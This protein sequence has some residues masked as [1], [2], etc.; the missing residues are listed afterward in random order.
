[1]TDNEMRKMSRRELLE[2]LVEQ[3]EENEKLKKEL[4]ETKAALDDKNI[5]IENSGSIAQAALKLN[6]VF[7]AA[8]EAAK[9]YLESVKNITRES[10]RKD[11]VLKKKRK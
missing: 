11:E 10:K 4:E 5:I 6:K 9:Q 7:E 1:M 2:L 8:D 3:M